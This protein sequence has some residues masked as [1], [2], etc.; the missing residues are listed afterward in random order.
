MISPLAV[1]SAIAS[2]LGS[3]NIARYVVTKGIEKRRK[4]K[5]YKRLAAN[6]AKAVDF[7]EKLYTAASD[8]ISPEEAAKA[9]AFADRVAAEVAKIKAAGKEAKAD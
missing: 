3:Y 8:G 4:V 2:A 1:T 5:E 9:K 6:I 7:G